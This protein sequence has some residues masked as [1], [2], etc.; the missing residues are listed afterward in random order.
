[1][2]R[3][4]DH[5]MLYAVIAGPLVILAIVFVCVLMTQNNFTPYISYPSG[6]IISEIDTFGGFP[7]YGVDMEIVQ[8]PEEQSEK[9]IQQLREK[10]LEDLPLPEDLQYTLSSD[11]DTSMLADISSGLWWFRNDDTYDGGMLNGRYTNFTFIVY[12]LDSCTYYHLKYVF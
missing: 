1:M 6:S 12:D 8:I 9:F 4:K 3:K 11:P 7:A 2:R 5:S 10:G